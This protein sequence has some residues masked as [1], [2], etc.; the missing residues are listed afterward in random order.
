MPPEAPPLGAYAACSGSESGGFQSAQVAFPAG[1]M[2]HEPS[3]MLR[4]EWTAGV[5]EGT[6]GVPEWAAGFPEWAAGFPEWAEAAVHQQGRLT[7]P[8]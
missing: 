7:R 2:S 4:P 8:W 6:A 1:W 3:E 5:P